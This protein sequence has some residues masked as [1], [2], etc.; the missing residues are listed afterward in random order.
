MTEKEKSEIVGLMSE[1]MQKF[2]TEYIQP[3]FTALQ[4]DIDTKHRELK[5]EIADVRTELEETRRGLK[6]EIADVR[7]ELKQEIADVR[8]EL[9]ETRRELKQ[10]IADVRVELRNTRQ[11]LKAEIQKSQKA[12]AEVAQN[13]D[14]LMSWKRDLT[15]TY[16]AH[17]EEALEASG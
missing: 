6:Q 5:Q 15:A 16:D 3:Q 2:A 17:R 14:E 4:T 11:E 13:V 9:E 1:V 8:T 7:T 12:N 10:D